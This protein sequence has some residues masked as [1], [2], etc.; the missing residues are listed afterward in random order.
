M[1]S[2]PWTLV[3]VD[4]DAAE[5]ESLRRQLTPRIINPIK[6]FSRAEDLI[7]WLA[8]TLEKVGVVLIDLNIPGHMG[9]LEIVKWCRSHCPDMNPLIIVAGADDRYSQE[10]AENEGA[11]AYLIKP[12]TVGALLSTLADLTRLQFEIRPLAKGATA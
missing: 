8:S 10:R 1:S 5:L 9:G 3:Y 11:D 4:D 2:L 12:V 6:L 7:A